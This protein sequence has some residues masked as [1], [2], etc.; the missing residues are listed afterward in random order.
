[1]RLPVTIV[2]PRFT[3]LI[4]S[5]PNGGYTVTLS[6]QRVGIAPTRITSY[7]GTNLECFDIPSLYDLPP[8]LKY[9]YFFLANGSHPDQS[10]VDS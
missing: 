7:Q 4:I 10:P 3:R 2:Y 8:I 1:M 6:P 5:R 9:S